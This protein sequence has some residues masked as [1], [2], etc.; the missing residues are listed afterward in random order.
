[1]PAIRSTL[2][3]ALAE[4]VTLY[5]GSPPAPFDDA[6]FDT[7]VSVEV[8]EHVEEYERVIADVARCCNRHARSLDRRSPSLARV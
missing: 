2:P 3:A 7:V 5:D 6:S 1:M 8:L 4:R